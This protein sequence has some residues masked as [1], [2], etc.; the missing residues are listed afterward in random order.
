MIQWKDNF[1]ENFLKD[2][3]KDGFKSFL[4]NN[5][6]ELNCI[7]FKKEWIRKG[8]LAKT[9]LAM[10]NSRGGI[11]VL[12]VE[13][14]ADGE[15]VPVGLEKF[16]KKE[17]IGN[18]ISKFISPNLDYDILNFNY[19]SPD[20]TLS[21][22]RKFQMVVIKDKP[23]ELPFISPCETTDLNKDTIYV[24]RDTKCEKATA[25]EIERIISAKI[26][27]IFKESSD[28]TLDQHLMQLKK[29]YGE[30]PEKIK[31]LVKSSASS[32]STMLSLLGKNLTS[33]YG[34]NE[35]TEIENPYYPEES[36]EAFILRM[37]KMKKLKIEKVLDLK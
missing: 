31:V 22:N 17:D 19:D 6:G 1:Y 11:I 7:D 34:H 37:I 8:R 32:M 13:E 9:I 33:I 36:Y 5:F 25:E 30:L 35:Y 29:L 3:S 18:E 23:E 16:E 10:A 28:L 14:K 15:L 24:R 27:T 21:K 12:G 2:P 4:Q 26:E 20:Y